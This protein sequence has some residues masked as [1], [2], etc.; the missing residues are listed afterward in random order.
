MLLT[1]GPVQSC[2]LY[3]AFYPPRKT[4]RGDVIP[5]F[6]VVETEFW[7]CKTFL[8]PN[9]I[10]C[11]AW[12]VICLD[13]FKILNFGVLP[14]E[15]SR[16]WKASSLTSQE[17]IHESKHGCMRARARA[18]V[19]VCVSVSVLV[20]NEYACTGIQVPTIQDLAL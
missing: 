7:G 8:I 10:Y 5:S 11:Y 12:Q 17:R 1:C 19:C 2:F 3:I 4:G 16:Y 13:V 9:P 18:C 6:T 15:D 20:F 14:R